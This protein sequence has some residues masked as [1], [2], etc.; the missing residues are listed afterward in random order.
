MAL[1]CTALLMCSMYEMLH[2]GKKR[3][4][5]GKELV[6]FSKRPV[7]YPLRV[8]CTEMPHLE[9]IETLFQIT[10]QFN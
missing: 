10:D 7:K 4:K 9:V 1:G 8:L 2:L 3:N 5:G 6:F